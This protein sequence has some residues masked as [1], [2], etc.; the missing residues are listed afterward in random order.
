MPYNKSLISW[1]AITLPFYPI[2]YGPPELL[3]FMTVK[4]YPV[5]CDLLS[6]KR[7]IDAQIDF[8]FFE[9]PP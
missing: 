7:G 4:G 5:F 6:Q 9:T 8:F 2:V 3:W 1:A